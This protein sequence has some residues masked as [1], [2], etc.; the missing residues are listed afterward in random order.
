MFVLLHV[1]HFTNGWYISSYEYLFDLWLLDI[2]FLYYYYFHALDK[3]NYYI[4]YIFLYLAREL[5]ELARAHNEP[6]R[7]G[8]LAR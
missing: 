4:L 2:L 8:I 5:N 1:L 3:C 6:S 7:V